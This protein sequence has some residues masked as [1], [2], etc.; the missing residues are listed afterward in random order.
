MV[1][2]NADRSY[3]RDMNTAL[4]N[5][6]TVFAS[7]NGTIPMADLEEVCGDEVILNAYIECASGSEQYIGGVTLVT[8]DGIR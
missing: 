8:F 3:C 2:K 5:L 6:I 7:T 1:D 4:A